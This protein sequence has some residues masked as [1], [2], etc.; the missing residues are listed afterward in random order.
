MKRIYIAGK[1][2]DD[3]VIKVLKNMRA[4]MRM[5]VKVLIDGFAPFVPWFDY[6]MALMAN[7]D[8]VITREMYHAFSMA[9]LEASDAVLALP[10]W[11]DSNGAKR[12]IERAKELSIP[13]Y[14]NLEELKEAFHVE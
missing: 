8:E 1:Y 2:N 9:W 6:H 10:S 11:V 12:E 13:V 14:Y 3:S 5:G 4:G 7:E